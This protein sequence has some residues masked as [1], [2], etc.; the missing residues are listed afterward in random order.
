[1]VNWNGNLFHSWNIVNLGETHMVIWKFWN[2]RLVPLSCYMDLEDSQ[3]SNAV[4]ML[5]WITDYIDELTLSNLDKY[6]HV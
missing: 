5:T 1:M 2:N 6:D 4:T 3:T